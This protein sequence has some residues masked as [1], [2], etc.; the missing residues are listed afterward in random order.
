MDHRR[1]DVEPAELTA[2]KAG[3]N[4]RLLGVRVFVAV[5]ANLV[6]EDGYPV[7]V[8]D[9]EVANHIHYRGECEESR[10]ADAQR[11]ELKAAE[12]VAET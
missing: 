4:S 1:C 10:V 12:D 8:L 6:S 2:V 11:A 5:D 7:V 3:Y 9:G